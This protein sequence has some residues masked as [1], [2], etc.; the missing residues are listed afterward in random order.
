MMLSSIGARLFREGPLFY[1]AFLV[2]LSTIVMLDAIIHI[3]ATFG[4]RNLLECT[5]L[6]AICFRKKGRPSRS[7]IMND[8]LPFWLCVNSL[9]AILASLSY[10]RGNLIDSKHIDT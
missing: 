8:E 4:D 3:L 1:D 2:K 5:D 9:F 10:D 7:I 6:T